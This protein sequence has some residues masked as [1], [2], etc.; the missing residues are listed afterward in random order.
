VLQEL[1][2]RAGPVVRRSHHVGF[3]TLPQ[4][5]PAISWPALAVAVGGLTMLAWFSL[6]ALRKRMTA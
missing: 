3:C 4:P 5:A 1:V 2:H 6:R